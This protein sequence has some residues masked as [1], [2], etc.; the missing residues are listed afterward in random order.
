[1]AGEEYDVIIVGSGAN[2][3]W[4][5]MQLCE[6][7]LKVLMLEM[8]KQLDP[9]KDYGEHVQPYD[10][11]FRGRGLGG[12]GPPS[13]AAIPSDLGVIVGSNI[14]KTQKIQW[15]PRPPPGRSWVGGQ[16]LR[17]RPPGGDR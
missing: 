15:A 3:G 14:A 1:M 9:E 11:K 17:A 2:G 5:A 12:R 8:G 16:I 6:S 13:R 4:A 7:G 10:L